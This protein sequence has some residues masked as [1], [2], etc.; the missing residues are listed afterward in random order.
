VSR[1]NWIA[2]V[3]LVALTLLGFFH[4]PGHTYLQQDCQIWAPMLER[5]SDPSLYAHD[6]MAAQPHVKL[7]IY[8][9]AVRLLRLLPGVD[10]QLALQLQQVA[11]RLLAG[12]GIYLLASAA[13]LEAPFAVA[14]AGLVMLGAVIS[15]AAVLIVE[16]EPV[17]RGF[18]LSLCMLAMGLAARGRP[19]AAAAAAGAGFLYHATTTVP[20]WLVFG[21]LALKKQSREWWRGMAVAVLVL[22]F[23]LAIAPL[24]TEPDGQS[25]FF[26]RI[27]DDQRELQRMRASYNWLDLWRPEVFW[28][29]G[30]TWLLAMAAL[31]RLRHQLNDRMRWLLG[32][33]ATAGVASLPG[34]WWL[35]ETT[36]WAILP[37]WQLQRAIA[38][39]VL[40]AMI[41][42]SLAVLRAAQRGGLFE[43]GLWLF[44]LLLFPAHVDLPAQRFAPG[45]RAALL[46]AAIG[47]ALLFWLGA[48]RRRLLWPLAAAGVLIPYFVLPG[49]AQVR[50][51]PVPHSQELD[52]LSLWARENTARDAVFL[53]A[54][55]GKSLEPGVFRA[56]ALRAV[57]VDWKSGGQVNHHL[58]FAREWWKRWNAVNGAAW[59]SGQPLPP[60]R[61]LGIDYVI[62]KSGNPLPGGD[63]IYRNQRFA[64][65]RAP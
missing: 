61:G 30:L 46:G 4:F 14:V 37:Q 5:I 53:F 26:D 24:Q 25:R 8:D 12:W 50:N 3:S 9:E 65:Y 63:P 28:H 31:W 64:V 47:I 32:G 7:T 39:T 55:C 57:Y 11:T 41:L 59:I 27:P 43:A 40:C 42:A 2:F 33:L 16:Y 17:P 35:L 19:I 6:P 48:R 44:V 45:V 51:Y 1:P 22:V 62:L 58:G 36:R 20:F 54:D 60:W 56:R 21:V 15:G 18:A 29:Y 13:G 52:A 34:A 49:P 10:T 23:L 38:F